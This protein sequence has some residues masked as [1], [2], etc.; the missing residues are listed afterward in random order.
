MALLL[1]T[2][3]D[4]PISVM[5]QGLYS[6]RSV[7][8]A[9]NGTVVTHNQFVQN[10][11]NGNTTLITNFSGAE[12]RQ[13]GLDGPYQAELTIVTVSDLTTAFT[14]SLLPRARYC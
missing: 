11:S 12:I 7:L 13:R 5:T 1:V 4:T 6:V 8:I 14:Q 3:L 2:N 10:L 9:K